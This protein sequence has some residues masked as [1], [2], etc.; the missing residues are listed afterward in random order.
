MMS[1]ENQGVRAA[2]VGNKEYTKLSAATGRLASMLATHRTIVAG[3]GA[4]FDASLLKDAKT[5]V[6]LGVD[7]LSVT[8]ALY[9]LEFEI[10]KVQSV[11]LRKRQVEELR[12]AIKAKGAVLGES[13]D[14]F[15]SSLCRVPPSAQAAAD[16]PE[17]PAAKR[18]R[19]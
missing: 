14:A 16:A 9:K 6:T 15:A 17:S 13:V 12:E 19:T 1:E 4:V 18:R 10:S 11:V 3:G 8:Y 5:T 7:T 2:L